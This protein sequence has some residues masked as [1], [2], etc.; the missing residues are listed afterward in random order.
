MYTIK[1]SSFQAIALLSWPWAITLFL[2]WAAQ[3]ENWILLISSPTSTD[4]KFPIQR[5]VPAAQ[6]LKPQPHPAVLSHLW[7]FETPDM[8]QS[9]GC[10]QEALGTGWDTAANCGL[11][12]THRTED[13]A[14][15]ETQKKK[16]WPARPCYHIVFTHHQ[17]GTVYIAKRM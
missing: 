6:V 11:R 13:L 1:L 4:W 8:V 14:W 5:N 3:S 17:M 2:N 15:P 10:P 9:G 16:N 12:L 7:R